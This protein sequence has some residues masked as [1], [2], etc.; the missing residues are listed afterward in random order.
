MKMKQFN[1]YS[2][3]IIKIETRIVKEIQQNSTLISQNECILHTKSTRCF[4]SFKNQTQ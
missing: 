1:L 2:R 3:I 4:K